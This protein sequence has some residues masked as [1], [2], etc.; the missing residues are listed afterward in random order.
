MLE[1]HSIR[2][3]FSAPYDS[4]TNSFIERARRTIFEGVATALL[5]SGAPARFW[6]EAE[7][8][9]IFTIN[10]LPTVEDPDKKGTYISRKNL[11][12]GSRRCFDLERLMAFGT[13]AT[14]Y[15]PVQRREGGKEPGQRRAFNGVVMGY[16][17]NMPAYRIWDLTDRKIRLVSFNFTICHEGYYPFL[18]K[19]NWAPEFLADL[20][21]FLL[22]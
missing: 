13:A 19:K 16:A 6:G 3:E 1:A 11:L 12:E 17:D 18:D 7:A 21:L 9:K 10:V 14:C 5:R 8:H 2:H 22:C 20:S 15:I 4:N